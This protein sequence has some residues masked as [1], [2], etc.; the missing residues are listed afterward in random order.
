[1]AKQRTPLK[2]KE[3]VYLWGAGAT[4]AEI[5]YVGARRVNLLMQDNKKL[6]DGIATRILKRIP[7]QW[8]SSFV[9]DQGMDIEKLISLLEASGVRQFERLADRLRRLYFEDIQT[10]LLSTKVLDNPQLA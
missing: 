4:Q 3:V 1:M 8:K 5:D 10:N 2:P 6:G 7:K 9:T